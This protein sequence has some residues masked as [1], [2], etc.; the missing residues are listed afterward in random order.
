MFIKCLFKKV[1]QFYLS[2]KKLTKYQN[3]VLF[4][5][6][7]I[8]FF[9]KKKLGFTPCRAEQPLQGMELQEKEAQ[10]DY[11]IQ[12]ICLERTYS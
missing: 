7:C 1:D 8:T 12:E 11:S 9:F 4:K 2:S 6:Y 5:Y 10:N 3:T